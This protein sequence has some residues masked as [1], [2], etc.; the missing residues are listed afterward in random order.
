MAT[1]MT[2]GA[3]V[4]ALE[5]PEA[6][7]EGGEGGRG[8]RRRKRRE[9]GGGGMRRRNSPALPAARG[10]DVRGSAPG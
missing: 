7:Q 3:Q 8:R 1:A 5:T 4:N 10:V 9:E 2:R 6:P